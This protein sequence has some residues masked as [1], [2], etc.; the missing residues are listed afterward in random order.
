MNKSIWRVLTILLLIFN[1]SCSSSPEVEPMIFGSELHHIIP[2]T[3]RW[4]YAVMFDNIDGRFKHDKSDTINGVTINTF[5]PYTESSSKWHKRIEIIHC[6]V[7]F[8]MTARRYYQQMIEANLAEMCYYSIP[9]LCVLRKT[10]D[11]IIYEYHVLDCGKKPNRAVIGRIIHTPRNIYIISYTV[12]TDHLD[13]EQRQDM[14]EIIEGA[15]LV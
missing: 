2:L 13:D 3:Y 12:K 11:D 15:K 7:G 14:I 1:I 10:S 4:R 8:L 6:R 9:K 5:I